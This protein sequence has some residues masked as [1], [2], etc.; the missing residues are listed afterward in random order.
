M[1]TRRSLIA[2]AAPFIA[3]AAP[4]RPPYYIGVQVTPVSLFD[5]GID[6]CLDL[7]QREAA[8][9]SIMLYTHSYYAAKSLPPAVYASDHGVPVRDSRS[10]T[11]RRNWVR[12]DEKRFSGTFLRHEQPTPAQEFH[13]RD[14][15][16]ELASPARR[17]GISV[18]A[19]ILEPQAADGAKFIRGWDKVLTIDIDGARGRG[20]CWSHPAYREWLRATA[21]DLFSTYELDGFQ[22]GAERVGP[23]SETLLRN[24][25]P[26]CFC[27]HCIER[28][29]RKGIDPDRARAAYAELFRFIGRLWQGQPPP[30]DGVLVTL[31]RLFIQY[32][33]LLAWNQLWLDA[34]EEI[35]QLLYTTVKRIKP[36]ADVGRHV[37][38]QRSSWDI[39]YR[40]AAPY[41]VMAEHADF[42]KPILY[43]D[44][45][46]PRM[47]A[48][49][50]DRMRKGIF[51]E[52]S[53]PQALQVL[54]S[55]LGLNPQ[56]EP[57]LDEL[58]RKGFSSDYVFRETRRCL[59]GVAGKAKVYAGIGFDVPFND[60]H[61]PSPPEA[62]YDCT[63]KAVEAGAH[64]VLASR[65][66]AEMRL[67]N[68]RAFGKAMRD[69]RKA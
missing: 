69:T 1:L 5:E 54:Y 51:K 58:D 36:S 57:S 16:A 30:A 68:L 46:G 14:L 22:Y 28:G 56:T 31:I 67:A 19:R 23:L 66:Y 9:N 35:A 21:E 40:A 38:H 20:P 15:F 61:H 7:L 29:R 8:V 43:H 34:D 49:V 32:P 60:T 52:F 44:I 2:S 12:H 59:A 39:F 11:L 37:D 62:V 53:D 47:R 26:A 42:I 4:P 55:V 63:V 65:D 50:V 25:K 41:S 17:R 13:D 3:A 24:E 10:R 27:P 48:W 45:L 18:Y 64:G 6:R 33:E